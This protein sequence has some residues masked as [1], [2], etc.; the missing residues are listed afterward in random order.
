MGTAVRYRR[1][2]RSR[3]FVAGWPSITASTRS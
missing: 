2:L 3:P 1:A